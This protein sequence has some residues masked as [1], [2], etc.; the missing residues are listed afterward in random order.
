[1]K[2]LDGASAYLIYADQPGQYQHTLKIAMLD[3]SEYPGGYEFESFRAK[4]GEK[5]AAIPLTTWKIL[6]VPLGLNH[7]YWVKDLE[8]D[9]SHHV[10][11]VACPAPGDRR[12]FCQLVSEL[13]AQTLSKSLP[14]WTIWM[15]EGLEGGRVAMVTMLHHAYCD[16]V[17]ASVLLQQLTSPAHS[18]EPVDNM[19]VDPDKNPSRFRLFVQ[20]AVELPLMF[21]RELP[22]LIKDGYKLRKVIK[23]YKKAGKPLPP[24]A[25]ELPPSSLLNVPIG[26]GRCFYYETLNLVTFKS[27][28]KRLGV[29]IND[30]LL[31][32]VSG[33]L[34]NYHRAKEIPIDGPTVAGIPI[35]LRNEKQQQEMLGNYVT[36]QTIALPID[37]ADP[38]ERLNVVAAS[39]QAMKT[40]IKDTKG[41][42]LV[43][44][45][46]LM[47][48]LFSTLLSWLVERRGSKLSPF[49]KLTVSNVPGPKKHLRFGDKIKISEWLSIGQVNIGTGLN[50]T[51]WSYVDQFNICLIANPAVIAD[52][53]EFLGHIS[54]VFTQYEQLAAAQ[55]R[56]PNKP[57]NKPQ[58]ILDQ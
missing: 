27:V 17:G 28:G 4:I 12:A 9:I 55:W 56:L 33:A 44:M 5:A 3:F 57:S 45:M 29:T 16:G 47:P 1:M 34:H 8:F 31:A 15:V 14:M 38:Q 13:Y 48:P 7:P 20:G 11:R 54:A 23:S 21:L 37:I 30:L 26:H 41:I 49:G 18:T 52:G 40:Y 39:A 2:R 6:R 51:A 58:E 35:N 53:E 50:I 10:R 43:G 36:S 25:A 32:V 19:G 42:R 46:E 22:P 24:N